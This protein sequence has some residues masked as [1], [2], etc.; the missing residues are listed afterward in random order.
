[1]KNKHDRGQARAKTVPRRGNKKD[2]L[3]TLNAF[4]A[5]GLF[6]GVGV[7]VKNKYDEE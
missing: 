2:C 4:S 5:R 1:M 7:T 3:V 6:L